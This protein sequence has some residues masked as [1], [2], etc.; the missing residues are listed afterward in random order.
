MYPS[1]SRV[2]VRPFVF[3][4]LLTTRG[5]VVGDVE[6]RGRHARETQS[7]ANWCAGHY[8]GCLSSDA[9]GKVTSSVA[10]DQQVSQLKF[11]LT[12]CMC[13]FRCRVC[14]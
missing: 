3:Q 13:V 12:N 4:D 8:I 14:C 6:K 5:T 11:L 9:I 7:S 10:L 2:S 1:A